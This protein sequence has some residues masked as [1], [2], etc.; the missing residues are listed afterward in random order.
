[1]Q[2][3]LDRDFKFPNLPGVSGVTFELPKN[4]RDVTFEIFAENPKKRPFCFDAIASGARV[5]PLTGN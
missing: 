2:E 4:A 3:M 5:I 1:M